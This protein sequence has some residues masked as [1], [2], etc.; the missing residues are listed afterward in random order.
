MPE[1]ESELDRL[2][3]QSAEV[4]LVSGFPVEV[5]RLRTR[6]L[7]RLMRILTKGAG[8]ALGQLNFGQEQK[9]FG[10]QL[11]G[12]IILAIPDA[13]QETIGFLQ[14]MAKPG[15]LVDK[16]PAQLSKAEAKGNEELF[17]RFSEEMFN[18][19]LEDT[20]ALLEVIVANEAPDLQA[21]GKKLQHLWT[22]AR[23]AVGSPEVL[24]EDESLHSPAGTHDSST[25][26]PMSTDG[27]TSTSST[28]RSAASARPRKRPSTAEA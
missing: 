2:D 17:A 16:P 26:L 7:F 20:I 12:I 1:E 11:L 18:P 23:K 4:K 10:A 5:V 8:P 22:V 19:E 14:S 28:S 13:E 24:P 27:E 6:Q 9:E 3:P 15:G 25:S 21:L